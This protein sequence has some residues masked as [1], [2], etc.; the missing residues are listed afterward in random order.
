MKVNFNHLRASSWAHCQQ[1]LAGI[2][3]LQEL[4]GNQTSVEC[5]LMGNEYPACVLVEYHGKKIVFDVD[6]GYFRIDGI[7]KLLED[8]DF[9]FK[10]SYNAAKNKEL[11]PL[12]CTRMY[13]LGFNYHV[14]A[15]KKASWLREVIQSCIGR[16]SKSYYT[17]DKFESVP[18]YV[19]ENPKILFLTRLWSH[20]ET[21]DQECEYINTT[22]INIIRA[23]RNIYGDCFIGGL[24]NTKLS[25][26]LAPDLIAPKSMTRRYRYLKIMHA[27]DICV[28]S[29]GLHGSTGWKMGEYIA[30]AK[31]VVS[32]KLLYDVP[33]NFREGTHYLSYDNVEECLNAVAQLYHNPEK[34]YNMKLANM[35]Y[36]HGWLKPEMLVVNALLI[37]D[38]Q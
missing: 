27:S 28:A 26:Q 14:Y 33:G 25:M 12:D 21:E 4:Y 32:E 31:A 15:G 37:V 38:A 8:C 11:F 24:S 34:L 6:D 19:V 35:M 30:A 3:K 22:R 20:G 36:Y 1:I 9:Y 10:R 5:G 29:M 17:A 2:Q 13:P 16:P 7:R 18:E 23:L